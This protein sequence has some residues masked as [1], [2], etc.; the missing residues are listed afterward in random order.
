MADL[1]AKN[2]TLT[3]SRDIQKVLRIMRTLL[4]SNST[5]IESVNT[6][7]LFYLHDISH[8]N[9]VFY[10]TEPNRN[11]ETKQTIF[12]ITYVPEDE[13]SLSYTTCFCS[14]EEIEDHFYHWLHI[15]KEFNSISFSEEE[16]FSNFYEEEI[17]NDFDIIDEDA[18]INPFN[19]FQQIIL[20]NFLSE[21]S[22][23]L[24]NKHPNNKEIENIRSETLELRDNIQNLTKKD[25]SRRLSKILAKIK[26]FS[27][28]TFFEIS[29]V[30]KKEIYKYLL[31]EGVNKLPVW[32]DNINS[33]FI[34]NI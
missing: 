27:I 15:I 26:K 18:D 16:E 17:F 33:F 25:F 19:N 11:S 24:E 30:A 12:P 34:S 13:D 5:I 32:I 21:T 10:I 1:K 2:Y 7:H 6:D 14:L 22:V 28:K 4:K 23:Y 29:D 20:Y 8:K 9:F 31:K 3:V